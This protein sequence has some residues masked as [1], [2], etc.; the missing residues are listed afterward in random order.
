MEKRIYRSNNDYILTGLCGGIAEYF[1]I[2]TT[3]VRLVFILL[4][5]GG[6]SGVLVYLILSVVIPKD[7]SETKIDKKKKAKELADELD[8]NKTGILQRGRRQN[9]I[10]M[11]LIGLG[12]AALVNQIFPFLIRSEVVWP[13]VLMAVGAYLIF[14]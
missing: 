13:V 8:G 14:K 10:G 4:T 1:G 2:D 5:V 11:I 12:L 3:I 7:Y 6:G 9:L